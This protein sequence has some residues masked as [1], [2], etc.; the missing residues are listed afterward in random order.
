MSVKWD[1]CC[2]L[3]SL[4]S[5]LACPTSHSYPDSAPNRRRRWP[6]FLSRPSAPFAAVKK[7]SIVRQR[8]VFG[9][10]RLD[11]YLCFFLAGWPWT[12]FSTSL[13]LICETRDVIRS[14]YHWISVQYWSEEDLWFEGEQ[15]AQQTL[16]R[17]TCPWSGDREEEGKV[18]PDDSGTC[19]T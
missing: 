16:C 3:A 11:F 6:W 14:L 19:V 10:R 18:K 4:N 12:V 13:N 15:T 1:R 8:L 7:A 5:G 9:V 17:A 2:K